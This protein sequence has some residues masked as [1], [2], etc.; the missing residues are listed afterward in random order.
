MTST[1]SPA[2]YIFFS[3]AQIC[4]HFIKIVLLLADPVFESGVGDAMLVEKKV[5]E[6][7]RDK[8]GA[9]YIWEDLVDQL[10]EFVRHNY[11]NT[12]LFPAKGEA[13]REILEILIISECRGVHVYIYTHGLT[14]CQ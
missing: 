14:D 6:C 1:M 3:F 8:S 7:P 12:S 9:I 4:F 13:G 10:N 2:L 5:S 11:L